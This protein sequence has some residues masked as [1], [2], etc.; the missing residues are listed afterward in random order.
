MSRVTLRIVIVLA[1]ISIL[2]IVTTQVYWVRKAF[3]LKE[4]QFQRDVNTALQ[5]VALR[6]WEANQLPP[7]SINPVQQVSTNY[8][9]VEINSPIN[10][11]LLELLLQTEFSKRNITDFEYGVYDCMDQCMI[12]VV[13]T[14]PMMP[15]RSINSPNAEWVTQ[16]K[17]GYYFAIQFPSHEANIASQMGIWIFSSVVLLVVIAFFVYTLMVILRQRKLSEVQKDFINNMTHEFKTPISTIALSAGVLQEKSIL[18]QPERL[19]SYATIIQNETQRLKQQVERVLHMARLEKKELGLKKE[20]INVHDLLR[21]ALHN[22][23]PSLLQKE[24]SFSLAFDASSPRALVD[25]L[26]MTNVFTNLLDNAIKYCELQPALSISTRN[27]GDLIQISIADNGIGIHP[28]HIKK[29]FDQFYR[30]PTGNVHNVKG[31]GLGL[32]YVRLMVE[33]HKGKIQVQS[34]V[35]KGTIFTVI[36]PCEDI[37][38]R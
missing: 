28:T 4:T 23:Q 18:T 20:M 2:G 6:I 19:L 37:L 11:P 26:H 15:T 35:G 14:A 21:D 30:V 1:A 13:Q 16:P 9:V 5:N 32:N 8:Y 10:V 12:G 34:E 22:I 17:E 33:A 31:F 24:G 7:T 27:Y 38:K 36:L 3:D 25:K 29:I